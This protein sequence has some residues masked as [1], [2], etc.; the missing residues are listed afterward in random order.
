MP[1]IKKGFLSPLEIKYLEFLKYTKPYGYEVRDSGDWDDI[2]KTPYRSL[3]YQIRMKTKLAFRDLRLV[4]EKFGFM[5][6]LSLL[7]DSEILGNIQFLN[8]KV[9]SIE[10]FKEARRLERETR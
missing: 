9:K 7:S 4:F 6:L 8:D 10:E 1:R 2:E 3:D 5:E